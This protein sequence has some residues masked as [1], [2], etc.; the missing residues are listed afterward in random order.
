MCVYVGWTGIEE[1]APFSTDLGTKAKW[2]WGRLCVCL[3][4]FSVWKEVPR[5]RPGAAGAPALPGP[6]PLRDGSEV[7]PLNLIC[8][9]GAPESIASFPDL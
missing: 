5:G 4:L 6:F 1:T 7:L 3:L 2:L 8:Y 9:S